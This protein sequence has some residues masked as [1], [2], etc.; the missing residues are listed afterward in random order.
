MSYRRPPRK[1][2]PKEPLVERTDA[3]AAYGVF[4]QW[5]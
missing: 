5:A 4:F 3:D 1:R 2:P